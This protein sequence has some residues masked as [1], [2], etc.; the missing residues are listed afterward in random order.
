MTAAD[1]AQA[2]GGRKTARGWVVRCPAH[3][4]RSPSLSIADADGRVLVHCFAGCEQEAVID[5][6]RARGLWPERPLPEMAAEERRQWR[7]AR[8][9]DEEDAEPADA[10]ALAGQCLCLESLA[11][12]PPWDPERQIFAEL[13]ATLKGRHVVAE[14]RAWRERWPDLTAAMVAAGRSLRR[15]REALALRT[16][17]EVEH[18]GCA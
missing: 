11:A 13:L 2:L 4:D 15:S 7:E 17:L 8:R 18:A 5:A 14:Y 16:L 6:L 9:R 10:F 1:I 12:R 3:N